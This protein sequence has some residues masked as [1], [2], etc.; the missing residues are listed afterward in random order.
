[1][2]GIREEAIGSG[3]GRGGVGECRYLFVTSDRACLLLPD[4]IYLRYGAPRVVMKT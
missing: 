2:A 4:K 1:M 3:V